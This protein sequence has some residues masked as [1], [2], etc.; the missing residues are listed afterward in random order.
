MTSVARELG[1]ERAPRLPCLRK[2]MAYHFCQA[3]R[4]RQRLVSAARLGIDT[5]PSIGGAPT[6]AQPIRSEVLAV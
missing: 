3:H 6:G 1:A 2:E 5:T 4:R